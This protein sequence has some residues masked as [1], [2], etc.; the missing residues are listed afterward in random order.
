MPSASF[1][2]RTNPTTIGRTRLCASTTYHTRL[3]WIISF[4]SS[5]DKHE[6]LHWDYRCLLQKRVASDCQ[7][8]LDSDFQRSA[9]TETLSA[10]FC[11]TE[12]WMFF[13]FFVVDCQ[14]LTT[15]LR[16]DVGS[17]DNTAVAQNGFF[18]HLIFDTKPPTKPNPNLMIIHWSAVF[19]KCLHVHLGE[20]N[21]LFVE[22]SSF[23]ENGNICWL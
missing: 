2:P 11:L 17:R 20:R 14:E 13:F 10:S 19:L 4:L 9:R 23:W 5:T 15:S 6:S 18:L 8:A 16:D 21:S 1:P 12:T 7:G 3:T 22:C